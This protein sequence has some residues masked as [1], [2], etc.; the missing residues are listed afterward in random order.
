VRPRL[1]F[2]IPIAAV[3]LPLLANHAQQPKL[4]YFKGKVVPLGEIAKK[5]GHKLDADAAPH[6]LVL[7]TEGGKVHPLFKDAGSRMLFQDTKLRDRP[8]RLTG[9]LLPGSEILQVINVHSYLD[10]KL[11]EVYYWCDICTIRGYEAGNCDCCGGPVE[12]K[13]VAAP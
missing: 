12:R 6:W 4:S 1:L 11:H 2:V 10:G 13:E 9:R 7:V 8:L 5:E 3:L